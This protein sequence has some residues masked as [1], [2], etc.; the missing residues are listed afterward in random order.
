MKKLLIPFLAL[1]LISLVPARA[2]EDTPLA[3]EMEKMDDAYKAMRRTEDPAE[4]VKLA[5]EAQGAVLKALTLT[6]E[7]V[8]EGAH[9]DGKEKGMVSYKKQMGQLFV[10]FCEMEEAF[11][12]KDLKKV[13]DLVTALKD[14]KKKGHTEFV[15]DE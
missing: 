5:L 15:E 9:P 4:G 14:A 6:P 1:G 3:K 11:L 7:L 8:E 2:E 12:A 13:Q 10:M